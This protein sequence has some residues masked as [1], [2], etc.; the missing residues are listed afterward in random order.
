M[1]GTNRETLNRALTTVDGRHQLQFQRRLHH[2][3]E[4]VWAAI[5]EPERLSQWFPARVELELR[6]GAPVRYSMDPHLPDQDGTVLDVD[7]PR[8]LV[9]TWGGAVLRFELVA[10]GDECDLLFSH[11]FDDLAGAASF[12][13]GWDACLAGLAD[14]VDGREPSPPGPMDVAHE[15][16]VASLG[17]RVGAVEHTSTGWTARIDRQLVRPAD[18]VRPLLPPDGDGV[19]WELGEGTGHGARLVLT[20]GGLPDE[21]TARRMLERWHDR[22]EALAAGLLDH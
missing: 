7:P 20:H 3:V 22:V 6:A 2:P 13:S 12:A 18:V 5:T 17:L 21:Q 16:M 19:R 15:Q 14:V 1:T 10:D 8:L 11:T 4:T 9:L